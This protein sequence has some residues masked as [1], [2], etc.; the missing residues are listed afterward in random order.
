M[1]EY[2]E[3]YRGGVMPWHC[4]MVEHL[5]IAS[6]FDRM[7]DA[8]VAFTEEMGL[9]AEFRKTDRRAFAAV[10][11]FCSLVQELRSGD[12][13]HM[14]GGAVGTQGKLLKFCNNI[15]NS[16]TGDLVTRVE[17]HA[18]H[19]DLDARRA[20]E[21]PAQTLEKI[22][23]H[24]VPWDSPVVTHWFPESTDGFVPTLR[25]SVKMW[26]LDVLG[27]MSAHFYIQRFSEACMQLM[28][29]IGMSPQ[30]NRENRR[31]FSTFELGAGKNKI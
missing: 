24:I 7:G 2:F 14:Q 30:Y 17:S 25:D 19:F 1:S 8:Y 21:I 15:Y 3:T 5:T 28:A 18:I 4:D 26:E 22:E 10:R 6:Y 12:V 11:T 9:G 20:V 13:L 27:H 23:A 31:G 16:D 29:Q